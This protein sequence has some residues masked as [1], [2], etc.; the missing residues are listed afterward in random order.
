MVAQSS[1]RHRDQNAP[2]EPASQEGPSLAAA[3]E[4]YTSRASAAISDT[5][6]RLLDALYPLVEDLDDSERSQFE[7]SIAAAVDSLGSSL[8]SAVATLQEADAEA[9]RKALKQQKT[10]YELKLETARTAASVSLNN[11]AAE[12]QAAHHRQMEQSLSA[13]NEG[14][15][16]ALQE[17]HEKLEELSLRYAGL[18]MASKQAEDG[19][20]VTRN[21]LQ[22]AEARAAKLEAERT[23]AVAKAEAESQEASTARD[24]LERVR[25]S[26]RRSEEE[27][28]VLREGNTRLSEQVTELELET[29]EAQADRDE[30]KDEATD[31][32]RQRDELRHQL[33][34]LRAELE[35]ERRRPSE[36]AVQVVVGPEPPTA[37]AAPAAAP[38]PAPPVGEPETEPDPK[39]MEPVELT[40]EVVRLR[41]KSEELTQETRVLHLEV[42]AL[43]N[44]L[45]EAAS[46]TERASLMHDPD[47]A[48]ALC[49]RLAVWLRDQA[50]SNRGR[51]RSEDGSDEDDD[52]FEDYADDDETKTQFT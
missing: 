20:R 5:K 1:R 12:M 42:D 24:E 16:S 48:K 30:A 3:K 37:A 13:A 17:A 22:A 2:P 51:R 52:D 26:A 29:E 49:R 15:D 43:I 31:F 7:S 27:C 10:W 8:S 9:T 41:R 21:L 25:R 47:G 28:E 39:T 36:R 14:G 35:A 40:Q 46:E 23:E 44:M 34:A 18:Q 32:L 6:E 33:V 11:Q 19:L 4:A 50:L 45:A 38:P